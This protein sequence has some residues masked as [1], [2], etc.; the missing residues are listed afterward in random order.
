AMRKEL[1]ARCPD[2]RILD[3]SLLTAVPPA[4]AAV[5]LISHVLYH[6][7]DEQW[8]ACARR[9]AGHLTPDG[10]L[11]IALKAPDSG[12]NGMLEHFGAPR[13]DLPARLGAA[14]ALPENLSV[15]FERIPASFVTESF[16]ETLTI[17]RFML[18]DRE[19][20][21][22]PRQPSESELR[23]YVRAHFWNESAGTGGWRYD[24]LLCLVR[25]RPGGSA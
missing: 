11:V 9:A 14:S 20:A 8:A 22:F 15:S 25:K 17:A 21:A 7:P 4:P 2:A 13:F 18:C 1:A 10:V 24:E 6:I 23:E 19:A 16:E 12:C 5:G 3:G